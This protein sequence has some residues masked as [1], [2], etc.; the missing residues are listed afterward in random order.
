MYT[1]SFGPL[2]Q[3]KEPPEEDTGG[4]YQTQIK[5]R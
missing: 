2:M 1:L 4:Q 3:G 5:E